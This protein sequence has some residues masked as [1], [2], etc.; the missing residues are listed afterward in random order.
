MY[1]I[2]DQHK[3]IVEKCNSNIHSLIIEKADKSHVINKIT[4]YEDA[5][6]EANAILDLALL[7]SE[8][9]S[10]SK[11]AIVVPDNTQKKLIISLAK[12]KNIPI[13]GSDILDAFNGQLILVARYLLNNKETL[14]NTHL[15]ESFFSRFEWLRLNN[16]CHKELVSV[17][18]KIKEATTLKDYF[19]AILTFIETGYI[20]LIK[21]LSEVDIEHIEIQYS[22]LKQLSDSKR[23]IDEFE[24]IFLL[25]K[26]CS[27]ISKRLDTL[28]NGI[29]ICKPK[30]IIGTSFSQLF[31]TLFTV[32]YL[33]EEHE[34]NSL[35]NNDE[36]ETLGLQANTL[37]K[38]KNVNDSTIN[39]LLNCSENT[40]ISTS[41]YDGCKNK[42]LQNILYDDIISQNDP[43]K[44]NE[45]K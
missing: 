27:P 10:L 41:T 13:A 25:N 30:E 6:D 32:S 44:K 3:I 1:G 43:I 11:M 31:I 40:H 28:G 16:N 8:K 18:N 39:W 4:L 35:L 14:L 26:I 15:C 7:E 36:I 19:H 5:Y 22:V 37:Q 42:L 20:N 21:D 17:L 45:Y 29:Y 24:A 9:T 12:S 34:I 23:K 33:N 2:P 38:N